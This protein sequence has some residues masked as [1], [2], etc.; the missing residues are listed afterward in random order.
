VITDIVT[1]ED[2]SLF[3]SLSIAPSSYLKSS[4]RVENGKW[5]ILL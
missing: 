2:K 1:K 5:Y 4:K 3:Q